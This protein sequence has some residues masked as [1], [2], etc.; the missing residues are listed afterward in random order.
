MR[1]SQIASSCERA[2]SAARG[3]KLAYGLTLGRAQR[4]KTGIARGIIGGVVAVAGSGSTSVETCTARSTAIAT[5]H[6]S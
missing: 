3:S 6:T 5:E 4:D 2:P 1:S